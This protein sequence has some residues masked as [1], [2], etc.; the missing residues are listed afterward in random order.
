MVAVVV[1]RGRARAICLA[2]TLVMLLPACEGMMGASVPLTPQQQALR[3]RDKRWYQTVATGALVGAAAGAALGA[4]SAG[5]D[6]G[7]GILIG[8][9]LGLVTGALTGLFVADR[10]LGFEKREASAQDR[11]VSAQQIATSLEDAAVTSE[12]V[13]AQNKE[14]LVLLARQYDAKQITIAQYRAETKPMRDDV[15][16][17]RKASGEAGEAL[18]KLAAASAEVPQLMT[19]DPR[20]RA[21][22]QRMDRSANELDAALKSVPLV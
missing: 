5:D 11:I 14:R 16:L 19:E 15:E 21:A 8:A 7:M 13:A 10:N 6:Y 17:M 12:T 9:G 3:D 20:I 4:A 1:P 2:L 22:Q 18:Q